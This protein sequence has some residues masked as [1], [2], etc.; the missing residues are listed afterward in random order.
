MGLVKF[1]GV[2]LSW[3]RRKERE[4]MVEVGE[5]ENGCLD[6]YMDSRRLGSVS[7]DKFF[8]FRKG[9][10][11]DSFHLILKSGFLKFNL[12]IKFII[13]FKGISCL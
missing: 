12:T 9:Y 3:L 1:E 4:L 11:S 13:I 8:E 10:S 6:G 2:E 5:R 7:F